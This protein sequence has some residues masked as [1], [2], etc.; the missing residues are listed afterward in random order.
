MGLSSSSVT[1]R[2]VPWRRP[3][4][5]IS[6]SLLGGTAVCFHSS[7]LEAVKLEEAM[8]ELFLLLALQAKTTAEL[9]MAA[10]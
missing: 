3:I 7:V 9:P 8:A 4:K 1:P 6:I 2:H 5:V 10:T